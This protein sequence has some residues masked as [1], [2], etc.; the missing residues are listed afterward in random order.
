MRRVIMI[1]S[2]ERRSVCLFFIPNDP[3]YVLLLSARSC[4]AC[5]CE[6]MR[7]RVVVKNEMIYWSSSISFCCTRSTTIFHLG[8]QIDNIMCH[9][10][11]KVLDHALVMRSRT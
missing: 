11:S 6:S 9:V 8:R 2:G 3:M 7:G 10:L 5:A 1:G 4:S